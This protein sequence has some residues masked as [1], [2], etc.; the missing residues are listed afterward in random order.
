MFLWKLDRLRA[1][2]LE[3]EVTAEELGMALGQL[4]SGK[5]PG[6]SDLLVEDFR[7]VAEK[8]ITPLHNMHIQA[9]ETG[10]L[11]EDLRTAL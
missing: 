11:P 9:D 4:Q 1:E 8:V 10:A 3:E 5:T 7:Y 6:P 2:E